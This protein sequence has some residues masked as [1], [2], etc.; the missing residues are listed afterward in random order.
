[1]HPLLTPVSVSRPA[2]FTFFLV[3]LRKAF[4]SPPHPPPRPPACIDAQQTMFAGHFQS[5]GY[6]TRQGSALAGTHLSV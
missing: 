4:L 1:M 3:L 2:P 5:H 6:T